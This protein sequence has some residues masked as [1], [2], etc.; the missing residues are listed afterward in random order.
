MAKMKEHNR[1]KRTAFTLIELLVVIAIIAILAAMLLPALNKAKMRAKQI[2]CLNNARQ[3]ATS[4][5]MY[6]SENQQTFV[7]AQGGQSRGLWMTALSTFAVVDKVRDCP[8]TSDWDPNIVNLALA[9]GNLPSPENGWALNGNLPGSFVNSY[10]YLAS[11]PHY[12]FQGG[13]GL[14]GFFYGDINTSDG[15]AKEGQVIQPS[16]TP[17]FGD[18]MWCDAP[19][20][21]PSD[22][23]P[24][25][26]NHQ[27][28]DYYSG[29]T[30]LVPANSND[31]LGRFCLARHG[32][33]SGGSALSHWAKGTRPPGAI[34]LSFFDTHVET[35]PIANLWNLPWSRDWVPPANPA[36]TV[37]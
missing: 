2:A 17:V 19:F 18:C 34:N 24:L 26:A 27:T 9:G 30:G 36:A 33:T 14:S 11:Q 5:Y 29:A 15:F 7:Y 8:A 12:A 23:A 6:F 10:V 35:V 22:P 20:P 4:T 13:Y 31:G 1:I 25:S 16:Q 37:W 28:R 32:S 21:T 3:V